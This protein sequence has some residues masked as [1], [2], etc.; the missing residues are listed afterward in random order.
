[1][2]RTRVSSAQR[3][4]SSQ[5]GGVPATQPSIDRV[6]LMS[7]IGVTSMGSESTPTTMSLPF[8]AKPSIS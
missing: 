4:A 6:L 8:V 2:G 1:M 5:S 3:S 7:Y